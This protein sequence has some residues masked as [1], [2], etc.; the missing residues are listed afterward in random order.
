PVVVLLA[1]AVAATLRLRRP[2]CD[3]CGAG[4]STLLVALPR[5]RS[6]RILALGRTRRVFLRTLGATGAAAAAT[7]AGGA[8][9]VARN[10][11]WLSVAHDII[12]T[13]VENTSPHP[14]PEWADARI[15]SYRRLGRTG[16]MVSDISLGS[17]RI[18]D[19]DIARRALDRG[20][21]YFDT[22]PD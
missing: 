13:K 15:R 17:G 4:P 18:T 6:E 22:A 8:A 3:A 11:G 14:R 2:V 19:A 9:A 7:V 10:R 5:E 12:A 20:L 1:G 16:A 21:N